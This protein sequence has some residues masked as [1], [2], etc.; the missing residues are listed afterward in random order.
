MANPVPPT[1]TPEIS[2]TPAET[3]VAVV[4]ITPSAVV[5]GTPAVSEPPVITDVPVIT[6]VPTAV[7]TVVPTA[8]APATVSDSSI[9]SDPANTT[10]TSAVKGT[11][12]FNKKGKTAGETV[13]ISVKVTTGSAVKP[14]SYV[15]KA[16]KSGKPTT[17]AKKT[18]KT[19][20]N[21]TPTAKG[22]YKI[23]VY[24]YDANNK[25]VT[26]LTKNYSVKKRVITIKSFK[27]N[28]KS[29]QK[30]GTKITIT[31]KATATVG[32]VR[33]KFII[34]NSK[35]KTVASKSYSAKAKKI[36]KAKAK[37]TYTI[38]L[39]VKNG[40]GVEVSKVK[41]FKIK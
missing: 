17:I 14:Y 16:T 36:W 9:T 34:K 32:K 29:G 18:K 19:T 15:Y 7:P 2:E 40:K 30:K 23:S 31:A 5:T 13:K 35:G 27:T 41:T 4:T 10:T 1:A 3:P 11:I 28:K 39:Y 6:A 33:Y 20:A 24:V 38:T 8:T 21:W 37:G 26:T 22:T 25:K 12:S